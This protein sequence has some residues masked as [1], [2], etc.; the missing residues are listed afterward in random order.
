MTSWDTKFMGLAEHIATWSKDRGRKIAAVIVGV[1]NEIR[2]TGFN[3]IPRGVRDDLE[4]R[5]S[6][7]TK[8]K[9]IWGAHAERNAI[10]NAAR[11]GVPL[12][13]CRIYSTAFPCVD[14]VIAIIQSGFVELITRAPNMDD[15]QWGESYKRAQIMLNEAGIKVRLLDDK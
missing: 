10:Y 3:G 13:G 5:H 9:Y 12:K 8:E 1:D 14:C 15:P 2:S 11:I 7:E 6:R 4:E